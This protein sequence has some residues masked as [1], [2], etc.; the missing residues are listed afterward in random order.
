M[1]I[2]NKRKDA[3]LVTDEQ[4]AKTKAVLL[5]AGRDALLQV[6]AHEAVWVKLEK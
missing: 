3:Q 6:A 5:Q 2:K 4:K 1:T